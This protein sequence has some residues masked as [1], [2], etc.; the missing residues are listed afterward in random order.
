[1][2]VASCNYACRALNELKT[3][4]PD[5][6]KNIVASNPGFFA[7]WT[8]GADIEPGM[9]AD[10]QTDIATGVHES[11]H[12]VTGDTSAFPLIGGG[13]IPV[14]EAGWHMVAPR[15]LVGPSFPAD[16]IYAM[17]YL[18]TGDGH[19]SASD[20]FNS[21]LDELNAYTHDL[22]V[23]LEVEALHGKNAISER[24][25]LAAMLAFVGIYLSRHPLSPTESAAI[26]PV[27]KTLWAQAETV[28]AASAAKAADLGQIPQT[29]LDKLRAPA[30]ASAM[31]RVL[32]RPS[33]V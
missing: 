4:A 32:G 11:V 14:R 8:T 30:V 24:D 33:T 25:G 26:V 2:P 28:W 6:W 10:I 7:Q 20:Y 18:S 3:R 5:E 1:M 15:I 22:H 31:A 13:S 9:P 27:I 23:A 16:D 17:T 19:A 21:L 12:R 29:Y